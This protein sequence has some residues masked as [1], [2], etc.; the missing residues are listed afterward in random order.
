MLQN[1]I[2]LGV[3]IALGTD[4]FPFEP[5]DGTTATV[6]EAEAYVRAGMTTVH[7]LRAAMVTPAEMLGMEKD[8]GGLEAGK[9]ADVIAV[10]ED[11]LQNIRALRT[12]GFVMKGGVV[13]RNDWVG[14]NA[15]GGAR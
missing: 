2:R 4:Q 1:A 7:A 5:N 8:L 3:K 9:Y 15:Q 12:I 10:S 11:P 13:V 14:L 6:A